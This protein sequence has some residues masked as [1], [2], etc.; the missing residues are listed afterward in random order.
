MEPIL[1]TALLAQAAAVGVD[2]G[3]GSAAL[4]AELG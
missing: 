2:P 3:S 1:H 4:V